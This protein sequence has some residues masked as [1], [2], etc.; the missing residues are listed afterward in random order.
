MNYKHLTTFERARNPK[1]YCWKK[2]QK[3]YISWRKNS[4]PKGKYSVRKSL[5]K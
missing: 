4:T 5:K 2:S 1:E 3:A